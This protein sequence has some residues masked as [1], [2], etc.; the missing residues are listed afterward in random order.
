MKK[1]RGKTMLHFIICDDEASSLSW[2]EVLVREWA[3][4]RKCEAEL[5]LCRSAEQFLFRWEEKKEADIMLLDIDMPGMDG[6]TLARRLREEGD[7]VQIIF[8]TGLVD[9][10]L[11]GYDVEAVSYLIKPVDREKFFVCL[12]KARERCR[13]A[14]PVLVLEM[15]GST[16]RVR[17][18]D[19]YYLESDAHDTLAHCLCTSVG[20]RGASE[21]CQREESG[22]LRNGKAEE[23]GTVTMRSRTGIHEMEMRLA[24]MSGSFFRIHRSYVV[25]LAYV[26]RIAKREVVMDTGEALPVARGRWEALNKAYLDYY[27]TRTLE[28][29]NEFG[30]LRAE[31]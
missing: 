9:Y 2:Q 28:E 1:E 22:R 24:Q 11:E 8:V 31:E 23:Q 17:L 15:A 16:A 14:E 20:G 3:A 6:V 27:R 13:K 5:T 18:K 30:H 29:K 7:T 10:V 4:D 21:G 26:S 12:D 19:I 25:N